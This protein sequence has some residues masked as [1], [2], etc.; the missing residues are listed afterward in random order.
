MVGRLARGT[1][2]S[3]QANHSDFE[4]CSA[5]PAEAGVAS[6]TVTLVWIRVYAASFAVEEAEQWNPFR[7][8]QAGHFFL[9]PPKQAP[10]AGVGIGNLHCAQL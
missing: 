10:K 5:I 3:K 2:H 9:M 7:K 4:P 8:S 1:R 6:Q